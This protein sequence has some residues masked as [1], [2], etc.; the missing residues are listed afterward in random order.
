MGFIAFWIPE[1]GDSIALGITT[2]LCTLAL[3]ESVEL[4]DTSD[5]TWSEIF[6]GICTAY[7]AIVMFFSFMDYQVTLSERINVFFGRLGPKKVKAEGNGKAAAADKDDGDAAKPMA[8][9][10]SDAENGARAPKKREPKRKSRMSGFSMGGR[11]SQFNAGGLKQR[12]D[13]DDDDMTNIDWI[14]RWTVLP[15]YVLIVAVML[16]WVPSALT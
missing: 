1:G 11:F 10:D 3:R 8:A 14:G 16:T 9:F 4:P 13:D 2:L 12:E 7:Q 15:S 5:I 6:V